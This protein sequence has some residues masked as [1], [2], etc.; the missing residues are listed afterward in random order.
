MNIIKRT[1]FAIIIIYLFSSS[2]IGMVFSSSAKHSLRPVSTGK[3]QRGS[4]VFLDIA[5]LLSS[6]KKSKS[7]NAIISAIT[8]LQA[9]LHNSYGDKYRQALAAIDIAR[10]RIGQATLKS[11]GT[12]QFHPGLKR[13]K[14][15][16]A[17]LQTHKEIRI[18]V[19]ASRGY[20]RGAGISQCMSQIRSVLVSEGLSWDNVV[21]LTTFVRPDSRL[22]YLSQQVEVRSDMDR[23]CENVKV[24]IT[25]VEQ[26]PESSSAVAME[27]L[28][29]APNNDGYAIRHKSI[30]SVRYSVF[31]HDGIREIFVGGISATTP[32]ADIGSQSEEA[33]GRMKTVLKAE[34]IDFPN[35]T[36]QWNYIG[37]ITKEQ[38]SESG[39]TDNY[40]LFCGARARF[41]A[42]S[43]FQNG[44]P[45][46][47]GIGT[48]R[49][50]N[51][52]L[53]A[54]SAQDGKLH[55]IPV[56]NPEQDNPYEYPDRVMVAPEGKPK[57]KPAFEREN[58]IISNPN[59]QGQVRVKANISGTA[60]VRGPD[61]LFPI[62]SKFPT[63]VPVNRI[64]EACSGMENFL[65]YG[66]ASDL[67]PRIGNDGSVS[68]TAGTAVEAQA[69]TTIDLI[70]GLLQKK[71]LLARGLDARAA[72]ANIAQIRVYVK[73]TK[74]IPKV[75]AICNRVLP[76]IPAVFVVS[77]VCRDGW[78]VEIEA[79]AYFLVD[80]VKIEQMLSKPLPST[81]TLQEM[82][83][84]FT[85]ITPSNP[86]PIANMTLYEIEAEIRLLHKALSTTSKTPHPLDLTRIRV[87]K[88]ARD[89]IHDAV[90]K[91]TYGAAK[92]RLKG[93]KSFDSAA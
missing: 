65:G 10:K 15:I 48:A 33:L 6:V 25:V 57:P 90:G 59:G 89:I 46:A 27:V 66:I 1:I 68:I 9:I 86:T 55:V 58:L 31:E 40:L 92:R 83:T 73:Y 12:S 17:D 5:E 70:C 85:S 75:K 7:I 42:D 11:R 80:K 2:H 35:I 53:I 51:L 50:V 44:Y 72:L 74:D 49:G 16:K 47:T 63:Q 64:V 38:A 24:P 60:S 77:D 88:G 84:L 79:T 71:A 52:E 36:R 20:D 26:P 69:W 41:Y 28:I 67:I 34:G 13:S 19:R 91:L 30:N 22:T 43:D 78:L 21:L 23:Y 37:G 14:S 56:E 29:I 32:S 54:I 18:S 82:P 45:A 39:E 3:G 87:L 4:I 93:F 76:G 8:N 62:D 81:G 61:V